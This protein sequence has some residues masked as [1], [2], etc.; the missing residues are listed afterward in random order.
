MVNCF[1]Q[2]QER[3]DHS[4]ILTDFKVHQLNF[5]S[6]QLKAV[7]QR[8]IFENELRLVWQALL[9]QVCFSCSCRPSF[10]TSV[11][12][13]DIA[14]ALLRKELPGQGAGENFYSE[15]LSVR[16]APFMTNRMLPIFLALCVASTKALK[17]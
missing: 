12:I 1:Q 11:K 9:V 16:C 7:L 15:T 2:K 13:N 10:I 3:N 14:L 4:T 6:V 5:V 17:L 8:E